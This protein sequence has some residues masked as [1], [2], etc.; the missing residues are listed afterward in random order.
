M[1]SLSHP[2]LTSVES[3]RISVKDGGLENVGLDPGPGL[4]M[5][6]F[7]ARLAKIRLGGDSI[8]SQPVSG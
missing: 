5:G 3:L 2:L 6:D 1:V 4:I 7:S 8:A